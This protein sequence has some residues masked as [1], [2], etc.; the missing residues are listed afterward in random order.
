MIEVLSTSALNLVQDLGRF[1]QRRYGVGTAGAMDTL[2]LRAGNR[3]LGNADGCAG[4]EINLAP[5]RIRFET[6][7]SFALTGADCGARLD[8]REILPWWTLRARRGQELSIGHARQGA[9][10]YL[11]VAGGLDLPLTLGSRSTQMRGQIGGIEGRPVQR[12]DRIA[13]GAALDVDADFGV[14]P[15]APGR[16]SAPGDALPIRVIPAGEYQEFDAAAQDAFWTTTW[17]VTPQSN[18]AGYRLSGTALRTSRPL[19]MRSHGIMPGIVQVPPGGQP[20][21]QLADG[22]VSG[23]Y[24]KIAT[25]IGAD[26]RLLGQAPLGSRIRFVQVTRAQALDA[27][28]ETET[29]LEKVTAVASRKLCRPMESRS[30]PIK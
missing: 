8:G 20:I 13:V 18:R 17:T 6:D 23:G 5:L 25:V 30:N 21:I 14:T 19:E 11:C 27:L 29:Y 16:P 9:R 26:L 4:L 15:P 1:G 3:L 28:K 2:A 12:G 10:A 24:P 22:N 7:L